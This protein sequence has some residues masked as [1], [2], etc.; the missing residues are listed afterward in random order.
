MATNDASGSDVP[1]AV[2]DLSM[3]VLA[4]YA[5]C[6]GLS[7]CYRQGSVLT[8][9]TQTSELDLVMIWEDRVPERPARPARRTSAR[10]PAQFDGAF[11]GLDSLRVSGW[12]V[13]VAHYTQQVF[14]GWTR[15]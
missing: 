11:G 15:E 4:A 13:D 3:S 14:E 6:E 7:F 2:V 8:G 10:M 9:L 1:S 12:P 5:C